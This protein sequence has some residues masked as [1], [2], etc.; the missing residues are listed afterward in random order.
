MSPVPIYQR[1]HAGEISPQI[2]LSESR[3][4]EKSQGARS[5][6]ESLCDTI[7]RVQK[8]E[9]LE[10]VAIS[11]IRSIRDS[12]DQYVYKYSDLLMLLELSNGSCSVFFRIH[13]LGMAMDKI[14]RGA[15][16]TYQQVLEFVKAARSMIAVSNTP[17][18]DVELEADLTILMDLLSRLRC[19]D[20]SYSS[21]RK[22]LTLTSPREPIRKREAETDESIQHK[23]DAAEERKRKLTETKRKKKIEKEQQLAQKKAE[24]RREHDAVNRGIFATPVKQTKPRTPAKSESM[25]IK[26]GLSL[27]VQLVD[28]SPR[29]I[30]QV[31]T[32]SLDPN[33]TL[34]LD[35]RKREAFD[36]CDKEQQE[37]IRELAKRFSDWPS[38][39]TA[40]QSIWSDLK[41]NKLDF[42]LDALLYCLD[43]CFQ[44]FLTE[45]LKTFSEEENLQE[46]EKSIE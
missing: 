22:R 13:I 45:A 27:A 9:I 32:L 35:D 17:K 18:T 44:S 10:E 15:A 6:L 41:E 34:F 46:T 23:L 42:S 19:H 37:K 29:G 33:K 36:A 2:H 39:Y 12:N 25:K 24:Q 16:P 20:S 7:R 26:N 40:A 3:L 38:S 14:E 4:S 31:K 1:T 30:R 5:R 28:V 11:H 21:P 43:D 8:R